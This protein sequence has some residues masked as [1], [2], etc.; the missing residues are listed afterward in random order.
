MLSRLSNVKHHCFSFVTTHFFS[1][2][3][4]RGGPSAWFI[5]KM[6]RL[7]VIQRPL[8]RL[9]LLHRVEDAGLPSAIR[10]GDFVQSLGNAWCHRIIAPRLHLLASAALPPRLLSQNFPRCLVLAG[11][12]SGTGSLESTHCTPNIEPLKQYHG[13]LPTA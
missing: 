5:Q 12:I 8:L 2:C 3:Y 1:C 13:Y 11:R 9:S 10:S 7:P 4:R 6:A